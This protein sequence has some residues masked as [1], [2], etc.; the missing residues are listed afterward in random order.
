MMQN[1]ILGHIDKKTDKN[2]VSHFFLIG[3]QILK[4]Y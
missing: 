3:L 2:I 4:K 1:K